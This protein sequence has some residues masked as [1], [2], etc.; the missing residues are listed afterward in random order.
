MRVVSCTFRAM[1]KLD[2]CKNTKEEVA[3]MVLKMI[4]SF[5]KQWFTKPEGKIGTEVLYKR[6][7]DN[8]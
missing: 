2:C 4:I 5:V 7:L 1:L 3:N 6:H 8:D